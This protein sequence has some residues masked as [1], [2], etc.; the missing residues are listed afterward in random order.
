MTEPE[1]SGII[2]YLEDKEYDVDDIKSE[3]HPIITSGGSVVSVGGQI[4]GGIDKAKQ[5]ADSNEAKALV[6]AKLEKEG[7]DV[8]KIFDDH[9][10][11]EI[12]KRRDIRDEIEQSFQ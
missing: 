11:Q 6:L 1:F 7:F 12:Q 10:E 5:I 4:G 2:E 3:M 8:L 9:K